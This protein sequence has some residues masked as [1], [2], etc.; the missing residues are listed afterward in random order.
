MKRNSKTKNKK[1]TEGLDPKKKRIITV[2]AI[3][4]GAVALGL[5]IYAV[6]FPFSRINSG[7]NKLI[8]DIEKTQ[9]PTVM[10]TDT[11]ADNVFSESS[12]EVMINDASQTKELLRS[13]CSV[14]RG[15]KYSG[16]GT[17]SYSAWGIRLTVS[18][19]DVRATVYLTEGK[20]YYTSGGVKYYFAPRDGE[21]LKAYEAFY[22][23]I[24]KLVKQNG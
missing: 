21:S 15:M 22:S 7:F 16:K 11:L 5:V 6:V 10:I 2:A 13:M 14:A 9:A 12:G 23:E 17:D 8:S 1:E 3:V 19:G 20:M 4:L 18:E 24:L